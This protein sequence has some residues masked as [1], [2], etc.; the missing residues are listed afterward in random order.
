MNKVIGTIL[1]LMVCCLADRAVGQTSLPP[2]VANPNG[3][4]Q[5][6]TFQTLGFAQYEQQLNAILRT[7]L[8][9]EREFVSDVVRLVADQ[10][11]PRKVVD[12]SFKWILNRRPNTRYPFIYFERI[13]RLQADKMEIEIPDF[14]FRIYDFSRLR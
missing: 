2:L 14:S 9:E 12:T 11:L 13:L 8:K 5:V 3:V 6:D 1:L 10:K 4:S 7:R